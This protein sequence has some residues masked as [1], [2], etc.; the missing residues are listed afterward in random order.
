MFQTP[1]RELLVMVRHS[2]AEHSN[3]HIDESIG[4]EESKIFKKN[5]LWLGDQI[6][7]LTDEIRKMMPTKENCWIYLVNDAI[8]SINQWEIVAPI[9]DSF[10]PTNT[11]K[12]CS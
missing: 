8:W 10:S 12:I 4:G 5:S 1:D 2:L 3:D 9:N 7:I 11:P 6:A